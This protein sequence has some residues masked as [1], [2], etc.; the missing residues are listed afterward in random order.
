MN[1]IPPEILTA[2]TRETGGGLAVILGAGCS[3]E[4]PTRLRLATY[5]AQRGYKRLVANGQVPEDGELDANDLA[6]V[7]SHCVEHAGRPALR[8]LLPVESFRTAESNCGTQIVVAL[9]REDIV[10][11]LVTLN[12]DMSVNH[13][14]TELSSGGDVAVISRQDGH[15]QY[16]A[17]NLVYLHGNVTEQPEHWVLTNED[18]VHAE[19]SGW[20]QLMAVLATATP[21]TLFAGMGSTA[22]VF[23]N[24]VKWIAEKLPSGQTAAYL[25][26]LDDGP[27]SEF[28]VS[29]KIDDA[30]YIKLGWCDLM[31][32]IGERVS[33][34]MIS[35][36]LD[37]AQSVQ[38][39][40]DWPHPG[41]SC[42]TL[43]DPLLSLGL[44]GLG[45]LRAVW[46]GED[47]NYLPQRALPPQELNRLS[48]LLVAVAMVALHLGSGVNVSTFGAIDFEGKANVLVRSGGRRSWTALESRVRREYRTAP[49]AHLFP[50][51][52]ILAH[53]R[54]RPADARV[55]I[56]IVDGGENPTDI[57]V[58][59]AQVTFFDC[60]EVFANPGMVA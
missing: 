20:H 22:N 45:R 47:L 27:V 11:T 28:A 51:K 9:I 32:A 2:V 18:L 38:H 58:G 13:A 12:L 17:K 33:K 30:H 7:A 4:P 46:L 48:E 3:L 44:V 1:V 36:L 29:L 23:A 50:R 52:A 39:E 8:E 57:A 6:A 19:E 14:L 25:A 43:Q 16:G 53:A 26:S 40:A 56:D 31:Q 34:E 55:P 54:N 21:V 42:A 35:A 60:D 41:V 5:Y 10:R 15:S 49:D 37:S 59:D 24:S